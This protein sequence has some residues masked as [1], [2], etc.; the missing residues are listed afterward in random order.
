MIKRI[1]FNR[2]S[3]IHL[4]IS[5]VYQ[6]NNQFY[7]VLNLIQ[8][9]KP[10]V[11]FLVE[12]NKTWTDQLQAL[13]T[14]YP[15][16]MVIPKE[17]TYGLAFYSRFSIIR[18]EV[19]YLIEKDIPSIEVDLS[20]DSGQIV[21]LYGI[22]PTPPVPGQNSKS[23]ERDAEILIVGK[24]SKNN[25][26]PS[27]VMGD[28]NDVAWSYTTS[29]FL[30]TSEMADPR[31]GRGFFSTFHA[32]VPIF[33]WPLDHVFLSRHFGLSKIK[34]LPGIGSDHF[35]IELKATL[36]PQ[37]TTQ[38]ESANQEEKVEAREKIIKGLKE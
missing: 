38:P 32:K 31:R 37:K 4:I 3:G 14:E 24:K 30:K 29:L 19:N 2:L 8:K 36:T 12:T 20:L 11:V 25:P 26:N 5:N 6:S 1:P 10:D 28:L 7:K 33:R 9:R 17:N 27:L 15:F 35:P 23:T 16:S 22:H 21:T 34:V 13:E 18:Q